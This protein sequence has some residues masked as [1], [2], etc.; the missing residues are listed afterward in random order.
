V[1]R[2][3]CIYSFFL[4]HIALHIFAFVLYLSNAFCIFCGKFYMGSEDEEEECACVEWPKSANNIRET[5]D[6]RK[7]LLKNSGKYNIAAL[8]KKYMYIVFASAPRIRV[9][10][11]LINS[12]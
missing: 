5:R 3:A 10:Y 4:G 8:K 12:K 11:N 7:Q 1:P 9:A 6:N 2:H